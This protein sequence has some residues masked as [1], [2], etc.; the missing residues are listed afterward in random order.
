[1]A[2][3]TEGFTE[4][5]RKTKKKEPAVPMKQMMDPSPSG[6]DTTRSPRPADDLVTKT[7]GSGG[8]SMF[9]HPFANDKS[10]MS[11]SSQEQIEFETAT[12]LA[13]TRNDPRR[14]TQTSPTFGI[15]GNAGLN[16]Q[17]DP[18]HLVVDVINEAYTN[19]GGTGKL[20]NIN[21]AS[22]L[23]GVMG[24]HG[25]VTWD[26]LYEC[27]S[28]RSDTDQVQQDLLKVSLQSFWP[29]KDPDHPIFPFI[30][31][32]IGMTPLCLSRQ[33]MSYSLNETE[34]PVHQFRLFNDR[35]FQGMWEQGVRAMNI[36]F[37]HDER[38]SL[39]NHSVYSKPV[40]LLDGSYFGALIIN[41]EDHTDGI[42][43][44][45]ED[46]TSSPDPSI[47]EHSLP[48]QTVMAAGTGTQAKTTTPTLREATLT[49]PPMTKKAPSL[50]FPLMAPV[51]GKTHLHGYWQAIPTSAGPIPQWKEYIPP[52]TIP[53]LPE[54]FTW[55]DDHWK[56]RLF[57]GG[58]YAFARTDA[59]GKKIFIGT[60]DS[61]FD[62]RYGNPN[63]S[64]RG[65]PHL[66]IYAPMNPTTTIPSPTLHNPS[67]PPTTSSTSHVPKDTMMVPPM[68]THEYRQLAYDHF[69][70]QSMKL[71]NAPP[72]APPAHHWT[73]TPGAGTG[74]KQPTKSSRLS[75]G[76]HIATVIPI[77][78][79]TYAT[80][81]PTTGNH[82]GRPPNSS[83]ASS[84]FGHGN[85]GQ[86]GFLGVRPWFPSH[87]ESDG[88]GN[89][90]N[91][92]YGGG[93]PNSGGSGPGDFGNGGG[94]PR[95][96]G[97]GP[98]GGSGGG[99]GDGGGG[100]NEGSTAS[101]RVPS[102]RAKWVY[103]PDLTAYSEYKTPEGF[104][105]WIEDTFTVMM[106]Q[107]LG[108]ITNP[109]YVPNPYDLEELEEFQRK[110][111]FTY[112]MLSKRVTLP[113]AKRI[114]KNHKH[115][116]N[117]QGALAELCKHASSS[118]QAVLARRR[119]LEI[120]T[121]RR[122]DPKENLTA[123]VFITEFE[124]MVEHYN[125]QQADPGMIL[126]DPMKKSLLQ[127]SLS[128]V[129]MLRAVSDRE[130]DRMVQNGLPFTFDE[131][132]TVVKSS[133]ALYDEQRVGRRAV[134]N[135]A[136]LNPNEE[137]FLDEIN[138]HM[139][140]QLKR[141]P[142]ASMNKE[143]WKA[144]SNEGKT[145][146]DKLSEQDKKKILQY[147]MQRAEKSTVEANTHS[148]DNPDTSFDA[149]FTDD[150]PPTSMDVMRVTHDNGV[151]QARNETHPGDPRRMMG[152][153]PPAR[154]ATI[155]FAQWNQSDEDNSDDLSETDLEQFIQAGWGTDSDS[156]SDA[157][158][159]H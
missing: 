138:V 46:Q 94:F 66:S 123:S 82:P 58:G 96:H 111:R 91:D 54:N 19:I 23:I 86:S 120:L 72:D 115:E 60:G 28:S 20:L 141:L 5:S 73:Q 34:I 159:F 78:P 97:N 105:A 95:R 107:G 10:F 6:I 83:L 52:I 77:T 144:I 40:S 122:Y 98:G 143:T 44:L 142:G 50:D 87:R 31:L 21:R 125:E 25:L 47:T 129:T 42:L 90:N 119:T 57:P 79:N 158:D 110:Q 146:W 12:P 71:D 85:G 101:A 13:S 131:Y 88:R 127:A 67:N 17:A 33:A 56:G 41:W 9:Q 53:E 156:N 104:P 106:A 126:N 15:F 29:E 65:G 147:A 100:D 130:S 81:T 151:S 22:A 108:E 43:S 117:A 136:L 112:M 152:S 51:S 124:T 89:N 121:K 116:L 45:P 113:L 93:G 14:D 32:I 39:F 18:R 75:W 133:A 118:T 35:E 49:P 145:T 36:P 48:Q 11:P 154:V 24:K 84:H 137:Q 63:S 114:V 4:V 155:K 135:V 26:E 92:P 55:I 157:S 134:H 76:S 102:R 37:A 103:K 148:M 132:L 99:G 149:P 1:M 139:A 16:L 64:Q 70:P 69:H 8:A 59:S 62:L 128:T 27:M 153:T 150:Q 109:H 30:G 140:N 7:R 2:S 80:N 38:A 61:E 74:F 68:D 3:D